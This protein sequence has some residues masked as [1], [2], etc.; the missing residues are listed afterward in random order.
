MYFKIIN[1]ILYKVKQTR[2]K[3][4]FM[5]YTTITPKKY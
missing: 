4:M 2:I 3:Y 5:K 1:V